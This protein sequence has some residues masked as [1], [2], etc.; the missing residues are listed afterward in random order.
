MGL[1]FLPLLPVENYEKLYIELLELVKKEIDLKQIHSL[2][3]A[4]LIYNQG[5]FKQ[6]QKKNPNSELRNLVHPHENGLIKIADQI[7]QTFVKLF[8]SA[9]PEQKIYF[10]FQ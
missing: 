2:F 7:F 3:I 5:D 9:F 10:D 1:R 8:E 6:M 4:S